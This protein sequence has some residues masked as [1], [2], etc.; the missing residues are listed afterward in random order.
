MGNIKLVGDSSKTGG[1]VAE[2]CELVKDAAADDDT[3]ETFNRLMPREFLKRIPGI[4]SNNIAR[5]MNKVK[6]L[7]EFVKLSL[8]E[9]E[10]V[11][12]SRDGARQ[13][14]EFINYGEKKSKGSSEQSK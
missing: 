4:H 6:N 11:I 3:G 5:V 7:V 9:L 2:A 1:A 12:G 14:Y 10:C 8:E 13:A